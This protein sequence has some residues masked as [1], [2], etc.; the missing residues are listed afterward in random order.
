MKLRALAAPPTAS[1][2]SIKYCCPSNRRFARDFV[3]RAFMQLISREAN[4]AAVD[5]ANE[6]SGLDGV[7]CRLGACLCALVNGLD[8]QLNASLVRKW[9]AFVGFENPIYE[10]CGDWSHVSPWPFVNL[11]SLD[12]TRLCGDSQGADGPRGGRGPRR[13]AR[14]VCAAGPLGRRKT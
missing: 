2:S 11:V 13:A 10:R 5:W 7:P 12:L 3:S 6:Q 9:R 14:I 4:A 8:R 1:A